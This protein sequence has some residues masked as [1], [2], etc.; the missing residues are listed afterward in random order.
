MD[1]TLHIREERRRVL[2][3]ELDA[4]KTQAERNRL[5][6]FATPSLLALEILASAKRLMPQG[7]NIRFLDPAFGTGAFYSALLRVFHGHRI[8]VA[9][10]YEIDP[11]YGA[12]TALLWADTNLRLH[13]EDFTRA[14]APGPQRQCN[15]LICNPPYVRHHHV[16][17]GEKSRL[18]RKV[19]R[20]GGILI[21]GLSGLYCYYMGLAH[22]WMADGG[23]AGWL[24][25]SEF[26]GVNYGKAVKNY[27]LERVTLLHIH[28]FD[29]D[30]VQFA[31]ALVSSAVVW[32][33]KAPPPPGHAVQF[34]FGGSLSTPQRS[35]LIPVEALQHEAKWTR[36][37]LSPPQTRAYV[38]V[39]ADFFSIKRG[40]ATGDNS[41]FILNTAQIAAHHLPMEMFR[42]ILPSPRYITTDEIMAD[43]QGYPLVDRQLF[44]LH[45]RLPAERVQERYPALWAYLEEGEKRGIAQRYLCLHRKP[46]YSQEERPAPSLIC[47]YMGRLNLKHGQLFR[48]ILNHSQATVAN[49]YL[50]L[51]PKPHLASVLQNNPDLIRQIRE[52]LR[53]IQPETLMGEGRVYGGGLHKLEPKE[54]ANVPAQ[55]IVELLPTSIAASNIQ[56]SLF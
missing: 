31:D 9:E 43:T 16:I 12:P 45:C 40:L 3:E 36:F 29:P 22:A 39:L 46:W 47:T 38:P 27:L 4:A 52:I 50:A 23:L 44:L 42:P 13:V 30:E 18:R 37:P 33:K 41:Y 32:F 5:G 2:Q 51:Y 14:E 8:A 19:V 49:V 56:I 20:A 1:D 34:T 17:N 24:I 15:L 10:G 54:L 55:A 7:Q 21:G 26:M 53:K 35:S 28:R 6:Q 25:P 48:F 11:H